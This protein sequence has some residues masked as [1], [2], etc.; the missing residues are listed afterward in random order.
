MS[1]TVEELRRWLDAVEPMMDHRDPFAWLDL[2]PTAT[3]ADIQPAFHAVARN[4]H[5]DLYRSKLSPT[6]FDRLVRIYARIAAAYAE[7]RDPARCE[8]HSRALRSKHPP[9][10]ITRAPT[11][12]PVSRSATPISMPRTATGSAPPLS[13][14]RTRTEPHL[15]RTATA[16][17]LPRTVTSTQWPRT[18]TQPQVT[19]A[20]NEPPLATDAPTVDF[21]PSRAM[22]AKALPHYRRAEGALRVGDRT[23]ALLHLRM[24]LASDPSST[25]LRAALAELLAQA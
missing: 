12:A 23:T 16:P 22:N 15:P 21:E 4:R 17:S 11:P 24:A 25:L 18:A 6:E 19:S 14:P 10:Q 1:W 2:K 8:A 3:P 7:L 13:V 5:P 20:S 9:P